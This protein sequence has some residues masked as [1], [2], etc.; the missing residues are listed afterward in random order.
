M[1]KQLV[2]RKKS[3]DEEVN[4]LIRSEELDSFITSDNA[5][6]K[7]VK[8]LIE[9][10]DRKSGESSEVELK[11]DLT[12]DE[13]KTH[14]ILA[15]TS[16]VLEM[17]KTDFDSK[18]ILANVIEK[19]ERKALSKDRKSREEIVSVAK[20]PNIN[21]DDGILIPQ[22]QGFMKRLFTSKKKREGE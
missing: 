14:T 12:D 18:C 13:I 7:A 4:S 9:V 19:K 1:P 3:L 21:A 17:D 5:T 22:K 15:I 6:A 11:T 20:Q 8:S 16:D 2:I 10:K